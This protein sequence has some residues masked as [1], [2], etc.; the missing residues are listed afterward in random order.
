[1]NIRFGL[2]LAVTTLVAL[3]GC[4]SGGGGGGAAAPTSEAPLL[5]GEE[6]AQGERPRENEFTEAAA[7][8][9][10]Q[11]REA[12]EG[13]DGAAART[14][15]QQAVDAAQQAITMDER[16]PLPYFQA[17]LA[18]LGLENYGEAAEAFDR[19]E[20]LRPIYRL[21]T[22]GVRERAWLDLYEQAAPMVN[23]GRFEDALPVLQGA[24]EIYK[25]RPEVMVV[26]GQVQAVLG[27]YEAAA[28]NL[29]AAID[30]INSERIEEMDEETR[31]QWREQAAQLP[32]IIANTYLQAGAYARAAEVIE[33]LLEQNPDDPELMKNLATAYVEMERPD[34]AQA[35]YQKLLGNPALDAADSY[36]IGIG[37]Y[38]MEDWSGASQAFEN[39]VE[40]APRDRDALEMLTRTL[41]TLIEERL[42]A[43]STAT[44]PTEDLEQLQ[45][46]AQQWTELD[47][48]SQVA[49]VI[50]AQTA[51]RLGNIEQAREMV[52]RVE[53]MDVL[54]QNL[55][56]R[57]SPSGGAQL[58]GSVANNG[59]E[60]GSTATINVTFYDGMGNPIGTESAT[61]QLPEEGQSQVFRVQFV[62]EQ[63]VMGYGYEVST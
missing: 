54:V 50:L 47:P 15:F 39:T 24:N 33:G 26:L 52:S 13:G 30:L 44:V 55:T 31:R 36:Q 4:A 22:E 58:T 56:L 25:N 8:H 43:D 37:L 21:E 9:L 6:L 63:Q 29:Q 61:V 38:R 53:Q 42:D 23:E 35:L 7:E 48:N 18:H 57:K 19:A 27:E 45:E 62:S 41:Q 10:E 16:N 3:G 17:A 60:A 34:T 40:A 49:H 51:N 32:T 28:Q 11:A 12:E 14:H 46:V 2:I 20:E 59:L 5:E 1:M